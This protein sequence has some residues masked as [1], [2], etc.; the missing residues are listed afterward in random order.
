MFPNGR[1]EGYS[2]GECKQPVTLQTLRC[3]LQQNMLQ[4]NVHSPEKAKPAKEN[5]Y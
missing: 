5:R 1:T 3:P 2:P 4:L